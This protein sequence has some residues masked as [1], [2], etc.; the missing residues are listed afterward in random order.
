MPDPS[1]PELAGGE[2]AAR[3]I[4]ACAERTLAARSARVEVDQEIEMRR[5]P[6][7]QWPRPRGL[8]GVMV[9]VADGTVK[10]MATAWWGMSTAA[11]RPVAWSPST[12]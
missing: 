5:F 7:E 6:Q 2:A 8:P 12:W 9:R 1:H 3:E 4:V 11:W 10:L